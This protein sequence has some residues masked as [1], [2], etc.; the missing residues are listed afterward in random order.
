MLLYCLLEFLTNLASSAV[1][2]VHFSYS[3]QIIHSYSYP[4]EFNRVGDDVGETSII[5]RCSADQGAVNIRLTH[6]DMANLI[7]ASRQTVTTTLAHL[8]KIGAVRTV[9]QHFHIVQPEHLRQLLQGGCIQVIVVIVTDQDK[10]DRWQIVHRD[11]RF[12][13]PLRTQP[14]PW[15]GTPGIDW[16]GENIEP[17]NLDQERRV[18]DVANRNS[19]IYPLLR[20]TPR[21]DFDMLG[22]GAGVEQCAPA[23]LQH[24]PGGLVGIVPVTE[25][26][27]IE[28]IG[29]RPFIGRHAGA[30]DQ[31]GN[32]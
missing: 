4:K 5:E 12:M 26:L 11:A 20:N 9:S 10:I 24:V 25:V 31:G 22:P 27:A 8:R 28:V 2:Q 1:V 29:R 3:N 21:L 7:G 17:V 6:Q 15:T 19:L 32:Y 16:V 23:K 13:H 30:R 14:L 18:I